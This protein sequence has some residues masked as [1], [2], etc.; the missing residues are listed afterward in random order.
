MP[1]AAISSVLLSPASSITSDRPLL[2]HLLSSCSSLD[3]FI[4]DSLRCISGLRLF[5]SWIPSLGLLVMVVG[6]FIL[7][8]Y[9]FVS[10]L[11]ETAVP[12]AFGAHERLVALRGEGCGLAPSH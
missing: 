11:G 10:G 7:L 2:L 9:C 4:W 1:T 12:G 5:F 8:L 6:R 3:L